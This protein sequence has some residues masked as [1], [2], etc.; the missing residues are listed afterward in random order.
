MHGQEE[1]PLRH[2][3]RDERAHARLP[4]ARLDH[5][6]LTRPQNAQRRRIGGM[7]LDV[8]VLRAELSQDVG[9]RRARLRVP[10]RS[11]ARARSEAGTETRRPAARAF[12]RGARRGTAPGRPA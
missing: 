9:F 5:H 10:L 8:W 3:R 1:L 11:A 6:P 7:D 2:R 12:G 4:A